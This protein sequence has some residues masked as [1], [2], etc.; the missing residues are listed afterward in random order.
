MR[1]D[2]RRRLQDQPGKNYSELWFGDYPDFPGR[3]LETGEPLADVLQRDKERLLG[4]KVITRFDAQLPH[5]PKI[6][7]IAK[8]LPLQIDPNKDLAAKLREKN[9]NSFTDVNHKP[10]IALALAKFEGFAGFKP[11]NQV[12]PL[13]DLAPLKRFNV[14][15]SD[16]WT[17][18]TLRNVTHELLKLDPGTVRS[19]QPDLSKVSRG[20]LGD[21][22]H[23]LDLLPRLQDQYGPAD[24]GSLVAG[25]VYEP[26]GV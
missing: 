4:Q 22:A 18:E 8:A 9:P 26:H 3:K 6:L 1:E 11:L 16:K 17:N 13:F 19:I 25:L 10:E 15:G 14:R 7:S 2:A 12:A 20:E 5:L 24:A 23:I 21:A